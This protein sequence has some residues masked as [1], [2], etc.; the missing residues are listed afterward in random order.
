MVLIDTEFLFCFNYDYSINSTKNNVFNNKIHIYL[1]YSESLSFKYNSNILSLNGIINDSIHLK[2]LIKIFFFQKEIKSNIE[3]RYSNKNINLINNK[4]INIYKNIFNYKKLCYLLKS[5][6]NTKNINY[7]D[8]KNDYNKIINELDDDYISQ[9]TQIKENE[10][11]RYFKNINENFIELE[12]K[13]N[14]YSEQNLKYITNFEIVDKDIKDF[15]I[16]NNIAKEEHFIS[17]YYYKCDNGK[18]LII[19][20]KDNNNFYEIGHFNDNE[21]FI[22]EYLIDE[23]EK[24]NKYKVIEYF[25]YHGII[26]FIKYDSKNS[27]NIINLDFLTHKK[28]YYYKIEE[29]NTP[30]EKKNIKFLIDIKLFIVK[31]I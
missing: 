31:E 3:Y 20:E 8:L 22:I 26:S 30:K 15:F 23:L 11:L 13:I 21:D 1:D 17:L 14:S 9:C 2:Q 24:I 12:Y 16:K 6:L 28:C 27:Q 4:V 19:F 25:Y 10:I 7:N 5:N 29:I 18:I